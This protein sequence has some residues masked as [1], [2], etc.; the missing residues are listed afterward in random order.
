MGRTLPNDFAVCQPDRAVTQ[1]LYR[2]HVMANKQHCAPFLSNITHFSQAFSLK[3]C[4]TYREHFINN[5]DLWLKVCCNR[6]G[7][8]QKHSTAVAFDRSVNK[9]INLSKGYDLVELALYLG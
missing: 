6:K 9:L 4:I 1:S 8:P 5:K 2:T 3:A 7:K